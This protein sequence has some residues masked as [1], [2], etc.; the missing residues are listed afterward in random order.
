MPRRG[1]EIEGVEKECSSLAEREK[2]EKERVKRDKGEFYLFYKC[3][4]VSSLGRERRGE[5]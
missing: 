2:R 5:N 4:N 1:G 3:G